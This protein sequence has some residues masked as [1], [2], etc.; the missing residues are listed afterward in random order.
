MSLLKEATLET[1][2]EG[3]AKEL[4]DYELAKVS[5]NIGDVNTSATAKRK[6]TLTF[7]FTPDEGRDE[8]KVHV[9]AKSTLAAVK[10][11][12]RTIFVG[13]KNGKMTMF[14]NDTKQIDMF[15]DGVTKL[16][17]AEASNAV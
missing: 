1:I 3:V 16:K 11:Y 17:K 14:G 10:G 6:I 5:E 9:S 2:A 13:K 15:D 8:A 7:E 12:T 4:F